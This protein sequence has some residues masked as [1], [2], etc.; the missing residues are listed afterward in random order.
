MSVNELFVK[1]ADDCRRSISNGA[2]WHDPRVSLLHVVTVRPIAGRFNLLHNMLYYIELM[3]DESIYYNHLYTGLHWYNKFPPSKFSR[4]IVYGS[5][6]ETI[7]R[8]YWFKVIL[9]PRRYYTCPVLY[10]TCARCEVV[11]I[12]LHKVIGT[13]CQKCLLKVIQSDSL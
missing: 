7:N 9:W 12:A 6:M 8:Y 5:R 3:M 2:V 1:F 11:Y 13:R 10:T 4:K